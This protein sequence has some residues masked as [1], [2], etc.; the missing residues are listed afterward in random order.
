MLRPATMFVEALGVAVCAVDMRTPTSAREIACG[1]TA[2][3]YL[4]SARAV[5]RQ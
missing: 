1:S 2:K 5:A 4:M 3:S